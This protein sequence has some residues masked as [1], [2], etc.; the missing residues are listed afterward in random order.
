M[1]S[2]AT[3]EL[4]S[5]Q[6]VRLAAELRDLT[7]FANASAIDPE[8]L[9]EFR[10]AVDHARSTAWAVQHCIRAHDDTLVYPV[11]VRERIRRV[12]ELCENLIKDLASPQTKAD[13]SA[14]KIL[15]KA[16]SRL[17]DQIIRTS[18]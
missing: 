2:A 15:Y 14:K 3:Q 10:S 12:V 11:L 5:R 4:I 17:C 18:P 6:L 1:G 9:A 8:I 16:A 13:A 7:L